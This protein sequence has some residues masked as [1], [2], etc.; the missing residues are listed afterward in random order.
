M[1][2]S[3]HLLQNRSFNKLWSLWVGTDFGPCPVTDFGK[4]S[5]QNKKNRVLQKNKGESEKMGV[6]STKKLFL[7]NLVIFW[8]FFSDVRPFLLQFLPEPKNLQSPLIIKRLKVNKATHFILSNASWRKHANNSSLINLT[9][10]LW[11]LS[12]NYTWKSLS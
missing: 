7:A 8:P 1:T 12:Q 2:H 6:P 4:Q 3:T 10:G 5:A 11:Q 9:P